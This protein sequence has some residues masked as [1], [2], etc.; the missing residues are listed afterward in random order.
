MKPQPRWMTSVLAEA[1][2]EAT[3]PTSMPWQRKAAPVR[4]PQA[5][6]APPVRTAARA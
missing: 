5:A 6:A 1:A 4:A 3:K 2:R